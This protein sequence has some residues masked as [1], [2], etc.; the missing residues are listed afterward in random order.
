VARQPV[1]TVSLDDDTGDLTM[2][3]LYFGALVRF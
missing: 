1:A 2:K 3:G